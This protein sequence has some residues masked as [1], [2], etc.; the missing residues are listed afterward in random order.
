MFL[1]I[2]FICLKCIIVLHCVETVTAN[3]V[4]C[5]AS[6]EPEVVIVRQFINQTH[7][8]VRCA[9]E[10]TSDNFSKPIFELSFGLSPSTGVF[11]LRGDTKCATDGQRCWSDFK[12]FGFALRQLL[13][14]A[15]RD[16]DTSGDDSD[17]IMSHSAIRSSQIEFTCNVADA[18]RNKR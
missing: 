8:T 11:L 15:A 4:Q 10:I 5:R 13:L 6:F 18:G 17:S 16:G 3:N 1:F 12:V 2:V 14:E 7:Q 9:A